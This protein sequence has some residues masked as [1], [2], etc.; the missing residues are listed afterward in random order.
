MKDRLRVFA[1]AFFF[2]H[3]QNI[4]ATLFQKELSLHVQITM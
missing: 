4:F 3:L 1:I 2:L